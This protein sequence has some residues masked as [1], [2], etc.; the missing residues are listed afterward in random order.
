MADKRED[1]ID[2][3]R[4]QAGAE[5]GPLRSQLVP[6]AAKGSRHPQGRSELASGA[7]RGAALTGNGAVGGCQS[8]KRPPVTVIHA[9]LLTRTAIV[10]FFFG[11]IKTPKRRTNDDGRHIEHGTCRTTAQG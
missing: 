7:G 10:W 5:R 11:L 8:G 2:R 3:A 9:E 1:G 6:A 4:A